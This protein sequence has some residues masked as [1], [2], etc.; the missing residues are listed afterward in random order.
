M[1]L[2]TELP[3]RQVFK[4]ARRLRKGEKSPHRSI[5]RVARERLGVAP[6]RHLFTQT[7]RPLAQ[8][9]TPGAFYGAYRLRGIVAPSLTSPTRQPMTPLLDSPRQG[10]A[11]TVCS[12]KFAD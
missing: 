10:R 3:I 12:P 4:H 11:A 7:V 5:L 1:G 8:L 6:M 2:F 9:T